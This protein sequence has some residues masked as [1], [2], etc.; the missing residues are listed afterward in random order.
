MSAEF[1]PVRTSTVA[2]GAPVCGFGE[3]LV[4]TV[5]GLGCSCTL[6]EPNGGFFRKQK[7]LSA[8]APAVPA[9]RRISSAGPPPDNPVDALPFL[10]TIFASGPAALFRKAAG[11]A[12]FA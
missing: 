4:I 10:R 8:V 6:S 9:L 12:D 5:P 3:D 7:V 2:A 1:M 11:L